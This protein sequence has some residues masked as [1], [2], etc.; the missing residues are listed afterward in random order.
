MTDITP[1]N[2]PRIKSYR[3]PSLSMSPGF[4]HP[5]YQGGS[6]LNLPSSICQFLG[7]DPLGASPLRPELMVAANDRVRRVILVLVDALSLD[8]MQRWMTDGTAPVWSRLAEQGKLAAI[9]SIVPSTTAAA[10]TSLWT[11]RSPAEHAIVGYELWLKEYGLVSNMITHSPMSFSNDAGSLARAG[12]IPERFLDLPTLGPHLTTSGIRSYALQHRSILH[13]GLSQM[14][15]KDVSLHG[16]LTP[17][18]LWVNLRHLVESNPRQKQ[19]FWV[20]TGQIDHFAHYYHPDDERT[21]AEFGDFSWT[22]EQQFLDKL[23]PALHQG[24]LI[25]LTADHGMIATEKSAHFDLRNHPDLTR[26]LHILPTGEN[27]LMYLFIR[28][29]HTEQVRSY[30]DHTWPGQFSFIDPSEAVSKGLFGPG[31]PHPRLSDRLGDLIVAAHNDAYL[32][33]AD[34]ENPLVGRHGGLSPEEMIVPLL[35]VEL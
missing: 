5:D 20:Y 8:R 13:S 1:L 7:A 29:G 23:S 22:F 17:S 10:L 31:T 14:Y 9:T 2:L 3:L 15:F 30:F 11:G 16:F 26:L 32:W 34:K 25:L 28:P 33:W 12:F 4:I 18:E 27:R 24:T 19:Y 35:S 21:A 6:I